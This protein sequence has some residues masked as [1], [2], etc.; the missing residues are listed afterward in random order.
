[1]RRVLEM[2]E[3]IPERRGDEESI[4]VNTIFRWRPSGDVVEKQNESI[5]LYDE[6]SLHTGFT[7]DEI[8]KDLKSKKELL[9]WL[10]K[11]NIHAIGQV[12]GII[13][14][15]YSDPEEITRHVR[16]N[17]LPSWVKQQQG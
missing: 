13:A 3:F 2:A 10:V 4:K 1:M 15:Y 16:K 14:N 17:S 12:G 5:R 9:E 7:K 11:N 6:L 8:E